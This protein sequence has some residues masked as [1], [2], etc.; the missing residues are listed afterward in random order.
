M[1]GGRQCLGPGHTDLSWASGCGTEGWVGLRGQGEELQAAGG[2]TVAK[3]L[4]L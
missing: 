2:G 3:S 4:H 1:V